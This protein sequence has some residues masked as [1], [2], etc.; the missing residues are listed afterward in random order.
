MKKE[1]VVIVL[2]H[3][4][5]SKLLAW[6][7]KKT[8]ITDFKII[9]HT[10]FLDAEA[11]QTA[12]ADFARRQGRPIAKLIFVPPEKTILIKRLQLPAVPDSEIAQAI[13]WRLKEEITFPLAE[14]VVSYRIL[15]RITRNDGSQVLDIISATGEEKFLRKEILLLKEKIPT[16]IVVSTLA[17]GYTLLGPRLLKYDASVPFGVL[18]LS[19]THCFLGFYK[20]GNLCF[21]RELPVSLQLLRDC[22]CSTFVSEKGQITLTAQEA[23]EA[24]LTIGISDTEAV[25][26]NAVSASKITA[27]IR[28]HLEQLSQEIRRSIDY[29]VKEFE[30]G[31]VHTILCAGDAAVIPG[32]DRFLHKETAAEVLLLPLVSKLPVSTKGMDAHACALLAGH[33]GLAAGEGCG[34]NIL[35]AVFKREKQEKLQNLLFRWGAFILFLV[36]GVSFLFSSVRA[37]LGE[38]RLPTVL[39]QLNVLNEVREMQARLDN[40]RIFIEKHRFQDTGTSL[41]LKKI[42]QVVPEGLFLKVLR[43]ENDTGKG[44]MEGVFVSDLALASPESVL[45]AFVGALNASGLAKNTAIVSLDK[46]S[47]EDHNGSVFKISFELF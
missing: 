1:S 29:Y 47:Q 40:A 42:S 25:Y 36:L 23:E 8:T 6:D 17:F 33:I 4:Q 11:F 31:E 32:L 26:K 28:P 3:G 35:P 15:R 12:I 5:S 43:L 27:M 13:R 22:L 30:E 20:E 41:L 21:Y 37:S 38:R 18:H 2:E 19:Q 24:L 44:E 39:L 16:D 7:A 34:I 9:A 10:D 46:G 14:A 45:T